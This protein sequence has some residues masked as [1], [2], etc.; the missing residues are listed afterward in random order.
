MPRSKSTA[1]ADEIVNDASA[2]GLT[3]DLVEELARPLA[4]YLLG[5]YAS[6]DWRDSPI[7]ETLAR[8]AALLE[9]D[10][11]EVPRSILD[12]LKKAGEA[13]RAIGVA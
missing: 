6:E 13:G 2:F 3:L 11:R 4:E 8:V 12:A 10:G 9:V 5:D 7:I 1:E